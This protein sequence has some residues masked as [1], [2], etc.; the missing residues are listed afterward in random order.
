MKIGM[1]S[2]MASAARRI[3]RGDLTIARTSYVNATM[4]RT[5]PAVR[6]SDDR[7]M[8][9]RTDGYDEVRDQH[10]RARR[11]RAH[12]GEHDVPALEALQ[13]GERHVAA[14]TVH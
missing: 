6:R 5:I 12:T 8:R 2:A 1:T 4:N 9:V 10:Q 11:H 13:T 7:A 3:G 14:L